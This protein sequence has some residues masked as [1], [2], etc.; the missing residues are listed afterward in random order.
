MKQRLNLPAALHARG[1]A[2]GGGA[3][4]RA[5]IG[6][7]QGIRQTLALRA[8]ADKGGSKVVAGP[9]GVDSLYRQGGK[10]YGIRLALEQAAVCAQLDDHMFDSIGKK[11]VRHLFR[12]GFAGIEGGFF[13][14]WKDGVDERKRRAQ[15]MQGQPIGVGELGV[16]VD[17]DAAARGFRT[18]RVYHI[19]VVKR[20]AE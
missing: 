12:L 5:R 6:K 7:A 14:V 3:D 9:G 10:P 15:V 16:R 13:F 8:H 2:G 20:R 1:G 17:G 18:K 19:R 4:G 11:D